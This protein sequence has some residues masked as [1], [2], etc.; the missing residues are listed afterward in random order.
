MKRNLLLAPGPTPVPEEVLH[1][2]GQPIFHHRTPQYRKIFANVSQRIKDV[3]LTQN[4][5]YTFTGSGTSCMEAAMINFHNLGDEVLVVDAGKFGERF[6]DIADAYG[7]KKTVIKI[8]Y[9]DAVPPA[10]IEE[11][12]KKN[13]K[14]KAVCVELCETSTAVVHDIK[15]I[16]AVVAKTDALLVV[17]AIS[18]LGAD[19]LET[20]NW[21]ADLVISGSQKAL[22]LPPG[23]AFLSVSEKARKRMADSNLPKFYLDLKL[24]DKALKADDSPFTPAI[25]LVVAL[26]KALDI[27]LKEGMENVFARCSSLGDYTRGELKKL[28]LQVFSNAPSATVSA[29]LVP[30]G[31]EGEKLVKVMRDEKGVTLAGGQGHLK[32]KIVRIAHMGAIRKEHIDEGIAVLK[33][34]IEELT[35]NAK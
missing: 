26:D 20:D 11:A 18:G 10:M 1:V 7:L 19:R 8:E 3:F 29:A 32:G 16:G 30:E 22:M 28:G 27:I 25:T 9:G 35:V 24:Y 33:E 23:L 17:D 14:I 4:T 15:A 34:T 13:P 12:L 6:G 31:I 2:L 5:V 21:N